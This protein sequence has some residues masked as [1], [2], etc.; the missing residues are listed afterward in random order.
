MQCLAFLYILNLF[1]SLLWIFIKRKLIMPCLHD[2]YSSNNCALT[3]EYIHWYIRN[4][5]WYPCFYFVNQ[6]THFLSFFFALSLLEQFLLS[7]MLS[8]LNY[9]RESSLVFNSFLQRAYQQLMNTEEREIEK[10]NYKTKRYDG[11]NAEILEETDIIV[12][13]IANSQSR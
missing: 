2:S 8:L 6:F 7:C 3:P 10:K 5:K 1:Q 4:I 13:V 9:K 12:I 11:S